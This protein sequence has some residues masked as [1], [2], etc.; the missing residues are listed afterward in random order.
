MDKAKEQFWEDID[1][2]ELHIRDRL[3]F[4]LKSDFFPQQGSTRNYYT[5][6]FYLFVPGS[7]QINRTTYSSEQF[8]LD[9]T[10]LIRYKTPEFSFS[11]LLDRHNEA[12]PLTRV[13]LLCDKENTPENGELLAEELK[14]M[15]NVV[16]STL[17]RESKQLIFLLQSARVVSTASRD[18]ITAINHLCDSHD[19]LRATYAQAQN[20]FQIKWKDPL[21]LRQFV[22]IDEFLSDVSIHYF[23]G[24]LENLR[25]TSHEHLMEADAALCK[26]LVNEVQRS[27]QDSIVHKNSNS[28]ST[29]ALEGENALYRA[30]LL[31]KFVLDALLLVTNRHSLNQR[32]ENWIGGISAG[33]AMLVYFTLYVW[34]WGIFVIN[35]E[36]FILLTVIIYVLK[37]RIK[38]GLRAASFQVAAKLFPDFTT[39]IQ[40]TDQKRNLGV[41][42][43]SFSFLTQTQV[44]Q[45][46]KEVRNAQFH[47]VLETFQRPESI[48]FYK[49]A[50]QINT[51]AKPHDP[52]L[53]ALNVIFRLNIYRFVRQ[54][55][56]P[57]ESH[58]TIDPKT[59]KLK[60]VKL[61]KVYHLNLI[62]RSTSWTEDHTPKVELKKLRLIVDKNGI[63]RID[64]LQ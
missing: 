3:Q 52:R 44:P 28:D 47:A 27:N 59:L 20:T 11:E 12:S 29:S 22:Y 18:F 45:E 62:I 42:K 19:Q 15:A 25:L 48:L 35:S 38:E 58:L 4:A 26:V 61:P 64:Q 2:G 7:L 34:L 53:S 32:F 50:V 30:N 55:S 33:V 14:L 8:Y 9:E 36:P 43:E 1:S 10:S 46:I 24:I 16:R 63:K 21:F 57:I 6:E 56:D 54:A 40:S 23:T 5:Q 51:I 17:R 37:D 60:N 39:V 13:I 41:L 49:R 31:N